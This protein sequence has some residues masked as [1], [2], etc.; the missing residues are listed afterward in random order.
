MSEIS[1]GTAT[2]T[3][4]TFSRETRVATLIDAPPS[5]VWG[6]LTD[7]G[8]YPT[9]NSTVVSVDGEIAPGSKITLVS[10]LD[11]SRTFKLK[12]KEFQAPAK[13]AWG[14]ALGTR[15]Y[16]ITETNDGRSRFEMAEKI[17]GPVFPLFAN[18][19]P[20]FDASFTRFAA[21]LKAAA[22]KA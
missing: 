9:W 18:K 2:T 22:E 15:T 13:L 4:K 1:D 16:T 6:L 5:K 20:S 21:D 17:G 14:D 8:N 12:V 11:P 7:A 3:S 10:T 19:I